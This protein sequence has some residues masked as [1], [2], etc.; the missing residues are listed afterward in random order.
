MENDRAKK[1]SWWLTLLGVPFAYYTW[2]QEASV[3]FVACGIALLIVRKKLSNSMPHEH[4]LLRWKLADA[5]HKPL[6]V[7]CASLAI[8]LAIVFVLNL[9]LIGEKDTAAVFSVQ[10]QL[11]AFRDS[12][13]T[14]SGLGSFWQ[15][16]SLFAL[17]VIGAF[18][19][20]TLSGDEGLFK[21]FAVGIKRGLSYVSVAVWF[22][23]A[24]CA[25]TVFSFPYGDS[26]AQERLAKT[27]E[28]IRV[29][30]K[31]NEQVRLTA[32]VNEEITDAVAGLKNE[33]RDAFVSKLDEARLLYSSDGSAPGAAGEAAADS[34]IEAFW[35]RPDP[36]LGDP[37]EDPPGDS[38]ATVRGPRSEFI[39]EPS[40]VV[41]SEARTSPRLKAEANLSELETETVQ[42]GAKLEQS[43]SVLKT[44]LSE[45]FDHTVSVPEGFQPFIEG[46][47]SRV[48]GVLIDR[49]VEEGAKTKAVETA[50]FC[51]L[52]PIEQWVKRGAMVASLDRS[53]ADGDWSL[54]QSQYVELE[55]LDPDYASREDMQ[56]RRT[57][58]D[59]NV[60]TMDIEADIELGNWEAAIN[61][62]DS[63]PAAYIGLDEE[64]RVRVMLAQSI[65]QLGES[66]AVLAALKQRLTTPDPIV[67]G[68]PTFR[69]DDLLAQEIAV[70][71]NDLLAPDLICPLC[72]MPLWTP[73]CIP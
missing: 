29:V 54:A 64:Q 73:G 40:Q 68:V 34:Y 2:Q 4:N 11:L 57:L 48:K 42:L 27:K 49:L 7:F 12:L 15:K 28:K 24:F 51:F 6:A 22:L 58:V 71:S 55:M 45:F 30:S 53:I 46:F 32:A 20:R 37:P 39:L 17:L 63:L 38:G 26:V 9:G 16:V 52:Q 47:V 61:A 59:L 1:A 72:H 31:A 8:L 60:R 41:V 13:D 18:V 35:P 36:G 67:G 44:V 33:E 14:V 65:I 10:S 70:Q 23:I 66:E 43:E 62:Y 5:L 19:S 50:R 3:W 25:F 69:A 21:N 56:S